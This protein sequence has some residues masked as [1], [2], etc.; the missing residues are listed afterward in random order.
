M[1]T[2]PAL[3]HPDPS[4][5]APDLLAARIASTPQAIAFTVLAEGADPAD[6]AGSWRPV[7]YGEFDRQATAVAKGLIACGLDVGGRVAI[8]SATRYEWAVVEMAAWYAGGVVVPVY[9]TAS[10]H[11][12]EAV[13]ADAAVSLAVGGTTEQAA[14]LTRALAAALPGGPA[15]A[16][17]A[18]R[19]RTH[20]LDEDPGL[21]AL[22]ALGV[23]VGDD[24]VAA[25]R[26]S[27]TGADLATIVYTSGT[28][29]RPK[30]ARISHTNLVGQVRN[31]AAAYTQVVRD[32]GSTIIFLPLAHVLARGLQLVCLANGMRVAHLSHPTDVPPAMGALHPTFLV[33]VPRVLDRIRQAMTA[34]AR[35]HHLGALWSWAQTV[36]ITRAQHME[37]GTRPGMRLRLAH[38][39]I[40]RTVGARLRALLG[41]RTDFLLCGA[42]ALPTDL[43]RLFRGLGVPVIEGYGL[44]ETTAPLT[45]TRPDDLLAGCVGTPIPGTSLRIADDGEV[46]A[47]G[48]GV[49]DG[50]LHEEDT[51]QAFTEDGWLRTGDFGRLDERGR[52]WLE[53][54]TRDALTTAGG[55]TV[56][57]AVWEER[58]ERTDGVAHPV[59]VGEGRPYLAALVLVDDDGACA[60]SPAGAGRGAGLRRVRDTAVEEEAQRAVAAAN[61]L[62]SRA[63]QAKRVAVVAA[64]LSAGGPFVTPTLKLR[65]EAL[66]D[67]AQEVIEDLYA[68]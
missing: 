31:V 39:L 12:A 22:V 29:A 2:T 63:E 11:Q 47:R 41:G 9:D 3:I 45:G 25:R 7:T 52:L 56:R 37:A 21:D 32:G 5:T 44:T 42:A 13:V 67:A 28:T 54:R 14:L 65:R 23:Q 34:Q 24:E 51:R 6:P 53:G 10:T 40:D 68:A 4:D 16:T 30:G 59:L 61:A 20:C 26:A 33:V 27:R 15:S 49:I 66:I 35:K 46:Q 18:A 50:Y 8:M 64:D 17:S 43:G 57:P 38:A 1:S 62:V 55:K 58:V 48:L 60:R 36:A 19:R